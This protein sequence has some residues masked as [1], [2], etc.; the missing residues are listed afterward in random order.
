MCYFR[1]SCREESAN[2]G[3]KHSVDKFVQIL[4]RSLNFLLFGR[5]EYLLSA[6]VYKNWNEDNKL[7]F[8][9]FEKMWRNESDI[10]KFL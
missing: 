10:K 6:H 2:K 4:I 5:T 3:L 7:K 1:Y 9:I 8:D